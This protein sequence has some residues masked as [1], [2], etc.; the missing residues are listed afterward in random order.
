[1]CQHAQNADEIYECDDCRQQLCRWCKVDI[2]SLELTV[3]DDCADERARERFYN[4]HAPTN[5]DYL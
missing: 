5:A 3:C 4:E 1:M 2:E